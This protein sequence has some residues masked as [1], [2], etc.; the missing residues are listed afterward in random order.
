MLH[1]QTHGS[2]FENQRRSLN[3]TSS[4]TLRIV[5]DMTRI[6]TTLERNQVIQQTATGVATR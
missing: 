5:C 3:A 4:W 2:A 6:V 1:L